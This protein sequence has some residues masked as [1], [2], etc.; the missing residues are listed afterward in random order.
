MVDFKKALH[1]TLIAEGSFTNDP[2]D[3]GGQTIFGIARNKHPL[4]DGWKLFDKI[5][6][7]HNLLSKINDKSKWERITKICKNNSSFLKLVE[8]FYRIKFWDKLRC[9]DFLTQ[10]IAESTFDYGVNAGQKTSAK[11]L[12]TVVGA[13]VD[14]MIGPKSIGA[15]NKYN[16]ENSTIDFHI[17]FFLVK[18]RRYY[19]ITKRRSKNRKYIFG[20]TSRSFHQVEEFINLHDVSKY[21]DNYKEVF[22]LYKFVIEGRKSYAIRKDVDKVMNLLE[23]V[24]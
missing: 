9:D 21:T 23:K 18:V 8:N 14:G 12:Q 3:T 10:E 15:L 13:G 1:K 19:R 5:L 6:K 2:D 24:I 17:K 7:M 16:I 11:A 22:E 20:W 4:W